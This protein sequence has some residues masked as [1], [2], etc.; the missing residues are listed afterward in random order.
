MVA[1]EK[2]APETDQL[3]VLLRAPWG[4]KL[5]ANAKWYAARV[6]GSTICVWGRTCLCWSAEH[7]S[8]RGSR[9]RKVSTLGS[10]EFRD[11]R[12]GSGQSRCYSG[13]PSSF[14]GFYFSVFFPFAVL[15]LLIRAIFCSP[16]ALPTLML[17]FLSGF[18]IKRDRS[19]SLP[20]KYWRIGISTAPS[21]MTFIFKS[22]QWGW[23]D[24]QGLFQ[25]EERATQSVLLRAHIRH[26][27]HRRWFI[28]YVRVYVIIESDCFSPVRLN[29]RH[30]GI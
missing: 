2:L 21:V 20:Y 9:A 26:P 16:R 17:S 23:E 28:G 25:S 11:S 5:F 13:G 30:A 19:R 8:A 4:E 12:E 10:P 15:L 22:T 7:S 3:R 1:I 18:G 27:G 29:K 24:K 14:P 6:C